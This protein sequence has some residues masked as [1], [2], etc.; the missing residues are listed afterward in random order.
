[1]DIAGTTGSGQESVMNNKPETA[2]AVDPVKADEAETIS[3]AP[4]ASV[5]EGAVLLDHPDGLALTFTAQAAAETGDRLKAAAQAARAQ[6][7]ND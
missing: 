3:T 7:Q 4:T 6:S 2:A 5:A 1:M